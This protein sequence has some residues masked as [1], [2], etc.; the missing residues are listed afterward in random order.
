[1][2]RRWSWW[3]AAERADS[4]GIK[5]TMLWHKTRVLQLNGFIWRSRHVQK[6]PSI[7]ACTHIL[8]WGFSLKKKIRLNIRS[9]KTRH[10]GMK[11]SC[12]LEASWWQKRVENIA[13]F[14]MLC[15]DYWVHWLGGFV[16]YMQIFRVNE[17][18]QAIRLNIHQKCHPCKQHCNIMLGINV[19]STVEVGE[20][21]HS[22]KV[23]KKGQQSTFDDRMIL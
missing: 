1:M 22:F 16:Y 10:A 20:T 7:K 2:W 18:S 5:V 21:E 14:I 12:S 4:R 15:C 6:A 13:A 8:K 17:P 9:N 19:D 3:I 11:L 23:H